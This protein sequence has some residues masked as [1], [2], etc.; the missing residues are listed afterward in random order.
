[1]R[2]VLREKESEKLLL[3]GRQIILQAFSLDQCNS[4]NIL[5]WALR[6]VEERYVY[7]SKEFARI[8]YGMRINDMRGRN[9]SDGKYGDRAAYGLGL[10]HG[11]VSEL[12]PN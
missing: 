5:W 11:K 12:D 8:A 9:V 7:G 4:E 1:M 3:E 10:I 2:E 6:K